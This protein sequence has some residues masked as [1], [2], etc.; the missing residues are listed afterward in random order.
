MR[1][2]KIRLAGFKTFVDPTTLQLPAKLTGIVGPN[3]CGKSNIID[4]IQWVMGE[5]SAKHLRGESMADVVF[6]GSASRKPV[7]QAMVELVFDNADGRIGGEYASY[8]EIAIRRTVNREGVSVYSLNGSR[9]RRADITQLFLGTGAGARSYAVIEQGMISRIVEA[10][11]DDLRAFVEEAAGVSKYKARRHETENRMSNTRD[12]LQRVGDL[13]EELGRQVHRLSDQ[14]KAAA[15]YRTVSAELASTEIKLLAARDRDLAAAAAEASELARRAEAAYMD[16]QSARMLAQ[17]ARDSAR[18]AREAA[19]ACLSQAQQQSYAAGAELTRLEQAIKLTRERS[20]SLCASRDQIAANHQT[21]LAR[22]SED[23]AQIQRLR[24]DLVV[25]EPEITAAREREGEEQNHL[26][27]DELALTEA[28]RA[29]EIQLRESGEHARQERVEMTRLQHLEGQI[30]EVEERH[31]ALERNRVQLEQQLSSTE[32]AIPEARFAEVGAALQAA[33]AGAEARAAEL[34]LA[35]Q[36]VVEAGQALA[37]C[38]GELQHARGRLSSLSHS[39]SQALGKE[40]G[41]FARWLATQGEAQAARLAE[42]LR[43]EPGWEQAV[44]AAL[45]SRLEL[46]CVAAGSAATDAAGLPRSAVGVLAM[47]ESAPPTATDID[48]DKLAARVSGAAL[49]AEWLKDVA[50]AEDVAAASARLRTEPGTSAVLTRDGL[51][52]GRNWCWRPLVRSSDAGVL[53]R[54]RDLRELK[55]EIDG[56]ASLETERLGTQAE[57]RA[58]VEALEGEERQASENLRRLRE[59]EAKLRSDIA[60]SRAR[61]EQLRQRLEADLSSGRHLL[62]RREGLL[63]EQ[64]AVA[65][66]LQVL[67]RQAPEFETERLQ[68][69]A[70]RE[71]LQQAVQAHR[72]GLRLARET[73]H[74]LDLKHTGL[75]Q[76]AEALGL[77][78]ERT[79]QALADLEIRRAAVAAELAEVEAPLAGLNSELEQALTRRLECEH[80]HTRARA[81]LGTAEHALVEAEQLTTEREGRELAT[82][83]AL[84]AARLAAHS[85]NVRR[86]DLR[87]EAARRECDLA[88]VTATLSEA[89]T[90][91]GLGA[92]VERLN[93]RIARL[94]AINLAAIEEHAEASER[95][96][97]L[98]AQQADLVAALETLELA[99]RTIDRETRQRFEDTLKQVDAGFQRLFP[100][101]FGGGSASLRLL[102]DNL[103]DAGIGVVAQPPGKRN[104]TIHLL[105]GGEKALTAVALIFAIF[106]LNPAPFC[107]LDEVDAPLDDPN[108]LRLCDLLKE[109]S[110]H[111]QFVFIS[112]NKLTMEIAEQLI[113]VTMQEPGVSRLVPVNVEQAVL[114]A[115]AV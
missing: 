82:R 112:H 39:Q 88:A 6:S 99:I 58:V 113:G 81:D 9:C 84:E 1:I 8:A 79:R 52:V 102:G 95:L 64:A 10:R 28:N 110:E 56:L 45:G 80:A 109:M 32:A 62:T 49:V 108:V 75:S 31:A 69:Q 89:D 66:K 7:Q 61:I 48:I 25:L 92:E 16:A 29:W 5:S 43:V 105:S 2:S 103:L 63:D 68:L 67:K 107:L 34:R 78:L 87:A 90:E 91:A 12:N 59:E 53:V 27:V 115:A 24:Q 55:A 71:A 21:A 35:R 111:V 41:E 70:R 65:E 51:W 76:Q 37:E 77:A 11:P 106:E 54:E 26:H 114:L 4:A 30:R 101:L 73:A 83:E 60:A 96:Q 18:E 13:R 74:R 72:Q 19:Q 17:Q 23:A 97:F 22:E 46:A 40:A 93:R 36:A 50:I 100:R 47:D 14:A 38:R 57:R 104:G 33:Q 42:L 85:V 98:E 86:E 20:M 3:G 94:G 15:T 44:E